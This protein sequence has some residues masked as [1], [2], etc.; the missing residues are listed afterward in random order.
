MKND[1]PIHHAIQSAESEAL[2]AE[3]AEAR[4]E[5]SFR[6]MRAE[7]E[8]TGDEDQVTQSPELQQWLQARAATDA[9]WGRW[10]MAVERNAPQP[11]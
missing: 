11:G 4:A 8:R 9:A 7:L 5:D 1:T 2:L 3:Q 6:A 10:A